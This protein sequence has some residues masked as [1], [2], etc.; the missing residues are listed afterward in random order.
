MWLT[1]KTPKKLISKLVKQTIEGLRLALLEG[2]IL[3]DNKSILV[4]IFSLIFILFNPIIPVH[5]D[6]GLW[7]IIDIGVGIFYGVNGYNEE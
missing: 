5:L 1:R 2:P 4:P 6:K 7:T 3:S